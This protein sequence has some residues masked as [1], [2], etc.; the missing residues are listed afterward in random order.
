MTNKA[1]DFIEVPLCVRVS[2][3]EISLSDR[4]LRKG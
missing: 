3:N 2:M 1:D 4:F